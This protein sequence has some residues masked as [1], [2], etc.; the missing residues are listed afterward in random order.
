MNE[1][2]L[3]NKTVLITGGTGSFGSTFLK[4]LVK[5]NVRNIKIL[6]RD[7]LKQYDQRAKINDHRI[8]YFLGGRV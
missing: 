2:N 7:E 8:S 4:E 6:S 1:I 3:K 5:T